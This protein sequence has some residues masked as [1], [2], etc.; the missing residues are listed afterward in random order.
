PSITEFMPYQTNKGTRLTQLIKLLNISK[1]EVIAF[2]DGENVGW[3]V[4]IENVHEDLKS[5]AKIITQSNVED[6]VTDLLEKIF[7]KEDFL[8]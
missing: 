7:L 3:L 2:G 5:Y 8:N 4:A 6:G 1:E